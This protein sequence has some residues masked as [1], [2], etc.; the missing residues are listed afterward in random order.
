MLTTGGKYVVK[1]CLSDVFG[2][3]KGVDRLWDYIEGLTR[4]QEAMRACRDD[5]RKVSK[6][7]CDGE[8]EED[9]AI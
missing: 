2:G 6:V 8:L 4:S 9:W 5:A 7:K 1:A 3:L